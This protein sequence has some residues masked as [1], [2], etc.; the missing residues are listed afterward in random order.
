M[1]TNVL[2]LSAFV[3]TAS[4]SSSFCLILFAVLNSFLYFEGIISLLLILSSRVSL[5][6]SYTHLDVYKRQVVT[7]LLVCKSE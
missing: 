3:I 1:I 2:P 4:F 7:P 6:V 5:S